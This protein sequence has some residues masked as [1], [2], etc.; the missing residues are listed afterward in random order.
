MKIQK[1]IKLSNKMKVGKYVGI[2]YQLP[3]L[4]LVLTYLFITYLLTYHIH[5]CLLIKHHSLAIYILN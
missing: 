3:C 4:D 5:T 2:T 1:W